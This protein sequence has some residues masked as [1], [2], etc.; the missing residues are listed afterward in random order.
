MQVGHI[1][2]ANLVPFRVSNLVSLI[3]EECGEALSKV[4]L[5]AHILPLQPV[6]E[7]R[8]LPVVARHVGVVNEQSSRL[9]VL[10]FLGT[11]L[12]V[13]HLGVPVII[14]SGVRLEVRVILVQ[15]EAILSQDKAGKECE[16]NQ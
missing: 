8:V 7:V 2:E 6:H 10:D 4:R 12:V 15:S 1:V 14:L 13:V 9:V 3:G 16:R 5:E 11:A